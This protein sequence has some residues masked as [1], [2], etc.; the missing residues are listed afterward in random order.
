MNGTRTNGAT[1]IQK[2]PNLDEMKA[3]AEKIK[4]TIDN[5]WLLV[6]PDGRAW[7]GSALQVLNVLLPHHPLMGDYFK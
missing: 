1:S 6:S 2:P 3:A 5:D 4:S 7:R